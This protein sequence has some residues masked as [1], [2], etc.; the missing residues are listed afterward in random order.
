VPQLVTIPLPDRW[1]QRMLQ[2]GQWYAAEG[3]QDKADETYRELQK[4]IPDFELFAKN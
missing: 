3:E 4:E 2:L 1:G